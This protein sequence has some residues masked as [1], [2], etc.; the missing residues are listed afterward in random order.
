M[1]ELACAAIHQT[2]RATGIALGTLSVSAFTVSIL[3]FV[4]CLAV[5]PDPPKA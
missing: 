2:R 3:L 1:H 4:A 5:E